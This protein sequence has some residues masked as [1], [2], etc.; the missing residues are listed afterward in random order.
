MADPVTLGHRPHAA[1]IRVVGGTVVENRGAAEHQAAEDQQRAHHPAHVRH[2]HDPLGRADVH[3]EGPV[4][5]A[6]DRQA[7][8]AMDGAF[9]PAGGA[10]GVKEEE[11]LVGAHRLGGDT[12]RSGQVGPGKVAAGLHWHIDA[13]AG[14]DHQPLQ[15][16]Q[17][18]SGLV[19]NRLHR[20]RASPTD[21]AV[22]SDQH[23]R[24]RVGE[25][26]ADR[27][28]AEAGEE[29]DRDGAELGAGQ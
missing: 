4:L 24:V 9:R 14:H 27:F 20:H 2:P 23:P 16:R 21:R 15:L 19:G 18:S 1:G 10:R 26:L 3:S 25:P 8:V 22:G 12:G 5:R 6:L 17:P 28:R 11:R 29:R 13:G 7:G